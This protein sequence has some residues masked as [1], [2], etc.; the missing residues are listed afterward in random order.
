MFV[1]TI[2]ALFGQRSN[3]GPRGPRLQAGAD[4]KESSYVSPP[5]AFLLRPYPKQNPTTPT[6]ATTTTN[7]T[8]PPTANTTPTTSDY[9]R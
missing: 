1:A 2:G 4:N 3:E 9:P 7:A 8:T 5:S 6:T